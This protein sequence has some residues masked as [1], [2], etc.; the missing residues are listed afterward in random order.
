MVFVQRIKNF[1]VFWKTCGFKY[2]MN[3]TIITL[4]QIAQG[5]V[6]TRKSKSKRAYVQYVKYLENLEHQNYYHDSSDFVKMK[7]DD[8]CWNEN[9]PKI[10]AWYL[11]QYYR[12]EVNNKYHGEGFTEWTNSSQA[13]P[14][15]T[16]HYQPHIPYDVG[17]YDLLNVETIKRQAY[18]AKKYGVYGFAYHWYWFSGTRT[19]EKPPQILLEHPEIDIH[20]CFDWATENWTSAWDGGTKEVIF[21]Q[22]LNTTDAEKFMH[23]ILPFIRD[24]RYIKIDGKP[25]ISIYR[26]DMFE[27]DVFLHFVE[28]IRTIAKNEGF[29]DLYLML[30]NRVFEGDVAEWGMDAMVEFP[31]SY[32]FPLCNRYSYYGYMSK[33][34]RA[35]IFDITPFV[36]Q[37]QYFKDYKSTDYYRSALVGF[38]N[39]S[40]RAT[41][42]CQIIMNNS[43]KYFKQWLKDILIESSYI[44][45]RDNNVVFINS[46]NEWAE[47]SHLEPD[48]KYG[49][50]YLQSVRDAIEECEN[51]KKSIVEERMIENKEQHIIENH[52]YIHCIESMGDIV[53]AE[54]IIRYIKKV[55]KNSVIHWIV[56]EQYKALLLN[57]PLVNSIETVAH[58]G[59]SIELIEM[60]RKDPQN[61]II[62]CHY[63]GRTSLKTTKIH[64]NENNPDVNE[65]TYLFFGSLLQSFC[66]SAGLPELSD[67]PQLYLAPNISMPEMLPEKYIVFHCLSAESTKDWTESKWNSLAVQL[68]DKGYNIVEIGLKRVVKCQRREYIDCTYE[69]DL[70]VIAK[71]ISQAQLFVGIDSG[72]A[73]IGNCFNVPAVLIFGE[74]KNF[75]HPMMYTGPYANGLATIVRANND[76]AKAVDVDNVYK[77]VE[78]RLLSKVNYDS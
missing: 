23:D 49:Y 15:F 17:Y 45:K 62:D 14:M 58:L 75:K 4:K 50:A 52:Y 5:M 46:W 8:Y 1:F 20:Y 65:K 67:Q 63:D 11:P 54:P 39:T 70:Q 35:D 68:L 29:P 73:H 32:L 61:I 9:S 69:R 25:V 12:M 28:E 7:E 77:A 53:S 74:Y 60:L 18:L 3:L 27:K 64:R 47:G 43:P 33:N 13:R 76:W 2:T 38:D 34:L 22:K 24:E 40:R 30:T 31:P 48:T 41:T 16:G 66:L 26:C 78:E 37:K 19:M 21:E 56:K 36:E 72:F 6:R 57:H 10:I 59:E 51:W 55:D 42:G 71:I 44:H